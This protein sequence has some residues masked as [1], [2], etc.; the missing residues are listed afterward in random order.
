MSLTFLIALDHSLT[1]SDSTMDDKPLI[2]CVKASP[3]TDA[4]CTYTKIERPDYNPARPNI[5]NSCWPEGTMARSAS[6][7]HLFNSS[8]LFEG[9]QMIIWCLGTPHSWNF[10]TN[11]FCFPL[12]ALTKIIAKD[13]SFTL[14]TALAT[15]SSLSLWKC[16]GGH[17]LWLV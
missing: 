5:P 4:P 11:P 8:P 12:A 15:I 10:L 3:S 7:S 17:V 16:W 2:T 13:P 1:S 9:L 14:V 6:Q